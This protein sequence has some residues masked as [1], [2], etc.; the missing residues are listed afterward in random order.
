MRDR[1]IISFFLTLFFKIALSFRMRILPHLQDTGGFFIAVLEKTSETSF[2]L[3]P[4][5]G[6]VAK[7]QRLFKD[8]PFSFMGKDDERWKEIK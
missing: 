1:K 4:M 7:R 8:D 3:N 2:D 5:K 6:P